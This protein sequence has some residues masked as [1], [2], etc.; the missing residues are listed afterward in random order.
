MDKTEKDY[1]NA[2]NAGLVWCLAWGNDRQPQ[3]SRD[4]LLQTRSAVLNKTA[5]PP[6]TRHLVAQVE[7][8]EKLEFPRAGLA[9]LKDSP[10]WQ[11]QTRI[12]L[13]YGGATKIKSYVWEAANLQDIRGASAILD[14]IN[15]VDLPGFFGKNTPKEVAQWL[16]ANFPELAAALIPEL[17]VYSTGGNILAFCPAAFVD[18]LADAIEKRYTTETLTANSCAV[19]ETFRL[20]EMRLGRLQEPME[21][22]PWLD[23]Y[24]QN[25]QDDLVKAY[26]G[27]PKTE[28]E[29]VAAFQDRK[30]FNEL[31]L[32]LAARFQQRRN[33]NN[34]PGVSRS[35]RRYPPM[36][37][38]HP[39][40]R[41][42]EGDRRLVV[43]QA[44]ELPGEPW[45]SEAV[46]RKRLAG[47]KVKRERFRVQEWYQKSKLLWP[48]DRNPNLLRPWHSG[49]MESWVLK[50]QRFL[51]GKDSQ[52][53]YYRGL[54]PQKV[55]EARRME[56]IGNST[57][58]FVAFIYADGNNM[59]GYI[60][61]IKT[62]QEYRE[63]S[64]HI[65]DATEQSVYRALAKHLAV[66]KLEKLK[67]PDSESRDGKWIHPFEIVTIGGDD[68]VLIVPA[69]Q[70]LAIAHTIC[71]EFEE[72]LCNIKDADNQYPYRLDDDDAIAKSVQCHRYAGSEPA[73]P[74]RCKLSMSAGV[75]IS[76][77]K[78]PIYYTQKLAEQLM[79]SAKKMAK[80]L[81][82]DERYQYHG[83]T[84]DFL[85]LK[86]V[87]MISSNIES[88]RKEGLTH[89]SAQGQ[90]MKLYSA[91]YTLPE[92]A[93]LLETAKAL[94][95][96]KLPKSQIYQIR[97]FLER[98]KKTAILNYLYFRVR[99]ESPYQ[100]LLKEK[101][102]E[103]WCKAKTNSGNI[104][105]WMYNQEEQIYETIWRDLVDL[106]PFTEES[107]ELN[108]PAIAV[109]VK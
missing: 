78:T 109:E 102:E 90:T 106:Y 69:N 62:A 52:H 19:G 50:F 89:K 34:I 8:L 82:N 25:Y 67:E 44:D 95:E 74:A 68:V 49:K 77:Y 37:E 42:D 63:F 14:R 26:F 29:I 2:L 79:K 54:S 56:E 13:V 11:Q 94:K 40:F 45:F 12:G 101:F 84:V 73:P 20:L 83:G 88:F 3:Y 81:K 108:K 6:E 28:A 47:Q 4:I 38:T 32:I 23:W 7:A 61:K 91:P 58:D 55:T 105:P 48:D 1:P 97:S 60:Q 85:A 16:E 64:K 24:R 46:A 99:L 107:E 66:H 92:L 27:S 5:P 72:F 71:V 86:S 103:A 93:G 10:I 100:E 35:S 30:S 59:G 53:P 70:A 43:T 21:N 9:T 15:L 17:I 41:R 80:T 76:E 31:A 36:F 18:N 22:T 39:Y 87:T 75:V 104:A 57:N 65:S 96:S 98:G 51:G 33:G